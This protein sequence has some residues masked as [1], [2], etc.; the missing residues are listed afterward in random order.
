M[1]YLPSFA[2]VELKACAHDH[3][4]HGAELPSHSESI[5]G[6]ISQDL[7]V[8]RTA[9]QLPRIP[10]NTALSTSGRSAKT[11]MLSS[12]PSQFRSEEPVLNVETAGLMK[13]GY[14]TRKSNESARKHSGTLQ[15]RAANTDNNAE[16]RQD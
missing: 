4:C 16:A 10:A 7:R 5:A 8:T 1:S 9:P 12:P 6:P 11:N 2:I 13:P 3:L 14:Q 15:L